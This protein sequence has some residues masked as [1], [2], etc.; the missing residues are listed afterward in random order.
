[1]AKDAVDIYKMR[2]S[3]G[4][5]NSSTLR[6]SRV[7]DSKNI[8]EYSFEDDPS[9]LPV[10]EIVGEKFISARVNNYVKEGFLQPKM[11]IQATMDNEFEMGDLLFFNDNHWLCTMKQNYH[12]IHYRGEV[13]L[14]NYMLRF[15]LPHDSTIHEYYVVAERP[16]SQNLNTGTIIQLSQ[17]EY[18]IRMQLTDITKQIHLKMRFIMGYGYDKNGVKVPDV[19]TV[20]SRDGT[21]NAVLMEDGFL[22]LNF[23]K[24]AYN[25]E[26]DN[27]KEMVADYQAPLD[28]PVVNDYQC[29]M[30]SNSNL[31]YMGAYNE[32]TFICHL[33]DDAGNMIEDLAGIT[34]NWELDAPLNVQNK[35]LSLVQTSADSISLKCKLPYDNAELNEIIGSAFKLKVHASDGINNF[36]SDEADLIIAS[37]I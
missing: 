14:C 21:A 20:D 10:I 26:K 5:S 2:M 8:T 1:M 18:R 24:A 19:Y 22:V 34:I 32:S 37:N 12:D 27:A 31:V 6:E 23:M 15:Q 7:L 11:K 16:Y 25:P 13:I 17:T 36:N 9:F 29:V 28:V 33:Y 4:K 3:Q 35:Y 30:S